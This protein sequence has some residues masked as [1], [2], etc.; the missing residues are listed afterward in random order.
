MATNF[1]IIDQHPIVSEGARLHI[2]QLYS[3][4]HFI[5]CGASITDAIAAAA[6]KKVACIVIDPALSNE[7]NDFFAIRKLRGLKA[8]IFVM[9][10]ENSSQAVAGSL[11]AGATGFFPKSA[12]IFQL[13]NALTTVMNG[14]IYISPDVAERLVE[15]Q[16]EHVKLSDREKTALVLYSSGL[17]ME[18]VAVSM[19]IAASTANE[20]IDR[21][22]A[23]FRAAGKQ[24]HNKVDLR[25]LAMEEGLLVN[26]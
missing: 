1:I 26:A 9:S 21:A 11:A 3:D 10:H 16:R 2:A 22:R 23:K 4:A 14:G 13:R 25:R 15:K 12:D 19:S 18:Q 17:T 24:A 8:P 5:Y 20:Y 7:P 6:R